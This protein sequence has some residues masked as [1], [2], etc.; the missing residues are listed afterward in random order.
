MLTHPASA[1]A[2]NRVVSFFMT[3]SWCEVVT[4]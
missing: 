4:V 3:V 2:A 1:M